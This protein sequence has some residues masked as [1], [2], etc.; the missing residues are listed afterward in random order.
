MLH[1]CPFRYW[2]EDDIGPQTTLTLEG[3]HR[4]AAERESVR[5]HPGKKRHLQSDNGCAEEKAD[6]SS[7]RKSQRR[8]E[9]HLVEGFV[10]KPEKGG[11]F[12][13]S[14]SQKR[15]AKVV[16]LVPDCRSNSSDEC[17]V[18]RKAKKLNRK[19][20]DKLQIST[21]VDHSKLDELK[22]CDDISADMGDISLTNSVQSKKSKR[23]T[24][25]NGAASGKE[26]SH[27]KSKRNAV[28]VS[29]TCPLSD[30]RSDSENSDK[31]SCSGRLDFGSC[32]SDSEESLEEMEGGEESE[33]EASET[34]TKR[35]SKENRRESSLEE[36]GPAGE[37]ATP[38]LA[39]LSHG[40]GVAAVKRTVHRQ[41]PEWIVNFHVVEN[42]IQRFSQ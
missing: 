11:S 23:K 13:S 25:E 30:G 8:H 5:T 16:T 39:P 27:K 18:S 9:Q 21:D 4:L 15:K 36:P 34:D 28:D 7:H 1:V 37:E 32:L 42:D 6:A 31:M 40:K 38:S 26:S 2:G 12:L 14:A 3:L 22:I 10:D 20:N 35:P 24:T 41:L 19:C 17:N 29:D 33:G